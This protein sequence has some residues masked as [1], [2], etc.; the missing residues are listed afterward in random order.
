M[1]SDKWNLEIE[2]CDDVLFKS[3][4]L[5]SARFLLMHRRTCLKL[6]YEMF[7]LAFDN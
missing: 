3:F 1:R 6:S 4:D 2:L 7:F 5:S